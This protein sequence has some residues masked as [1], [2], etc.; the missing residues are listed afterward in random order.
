MHAMLAARP[1]TTDS[2]CCCSVRPNLAV[3]VILG[4]GAEQ[5]QPRRSAG[6][7]PAPAGPWRWRDCDGRHA[8]RGGARAPA[9]PVGTKLPEGKIRKLPADH[10]AMLVKMTDRALRMGSAWSA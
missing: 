1:N 5:E 7:R 3:S 6:R 4:A 10:R 9:A 8:D 2:V